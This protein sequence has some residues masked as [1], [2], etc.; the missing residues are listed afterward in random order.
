MCH[1]FIYIP[2]EMF[3]SLDEKGENYL[4]QGI[5]M[6]EKKMIAPKASAR[7]MT[8]SPRFQHFRSMFAP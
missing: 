1:Q 3:T 2:L 4:P 7:L 8:E 6:E 5:L